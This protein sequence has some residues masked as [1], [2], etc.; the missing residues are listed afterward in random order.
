MTI[1]TQNR[2]CLFG[3]IQNSEMKLNRLGEIILD[4][5]NQIP[6]HFEHVQLDAFQ[7][8]P[9]HIHS[10]IMI[11]DCRGERPFAPTNEPEILV[12]IY[13]RIHSKRIGITENPGMHYP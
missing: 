1:C 10:I 13:S 5:W 2:E 4:R 8:M 6:N 7:I 9:N 11:N 3:E 12:I